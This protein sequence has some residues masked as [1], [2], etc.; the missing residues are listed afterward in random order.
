VLTQPSCPSKFASKSKRWIRSCR[1]N[2]APSWYNP[3]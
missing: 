1:H 2:A 3:L